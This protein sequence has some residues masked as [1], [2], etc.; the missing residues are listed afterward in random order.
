MTRADL[1]EATDQN[2][3]FLAEGES[4]DYNSPIKAKFMRQ[5]FGELGIIWN[6]IG[7]E[8][9]DLNYMLSS[10]MFRHQDDPNVK[11]L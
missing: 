8:N 11:K 3:N 4:L 7:K 6:N 2:K 9:T 1:Q 5:V 10:P